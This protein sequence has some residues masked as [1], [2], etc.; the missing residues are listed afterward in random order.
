MCAVRDGRSV[1]TTMGLT[2][3]EGLVMGT[4][5]GELTL[6]LA[7][8]RRLCR[9]NLEGGVHGMASPPNSTLPPPP[10]THLPQATSTLP[11]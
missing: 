5:S 8:W 10:H 1:D 9:S 2:P 6:P 11:S 7:M 4:R 3:L